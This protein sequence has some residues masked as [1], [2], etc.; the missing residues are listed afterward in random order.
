ML[1]RPMLNRDLNSDDFREWYYLKEEL[2]EF[3]RNK[4]LSITSSKVELSD[5]IEYF[6]DT[7]K[8]KKLEFK[9]K[10]KTDI[11]RITEKSKIEE[12][13]ICS[14]KHREFFKKKIGDSFFFP[15]VFQ[16]WLKENTGKTYK[17]AIDIFYQISK[18]KKK[19]SIDKQF[20]YNI[21]IR[22]FFTG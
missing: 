2:V 9:K 7:G 13:F 11:G 17:D 3:F 16:K 14:E 1:D 8:K 6:L 19:T 21:Y 18:E 12:N 4:N 10:V 20:E 5:R 22:D 15:V